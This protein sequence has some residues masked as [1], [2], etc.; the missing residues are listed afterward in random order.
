MLE[1]TVSM[2]TRVEKTLTMSKITQEDLLSELRVNINQYAAEIYSEFRASSLK[3]RTF[4]FA[5]AYI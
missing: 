4:S 2:S 5:N 1:D 3:L